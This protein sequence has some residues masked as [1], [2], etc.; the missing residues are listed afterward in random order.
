M[1][2]LARAMPFEG[3]LGG[4]LIG[5]GAA[6]MLLGAGRIAGV[7]GLAAGAVGLARSSATRNLCVAFIIGLPLGALTVAA[8]SGPLVI[9]YSH[10]PWILIA[11]GLLVGFGSRTRFW[12]HKRAWRLRSLSSFAALAR[13]HG[14]LHRDGRRNRCGDECVGRVMKNKQTIIGLLSGILFGVGLAVSGMCDPVRVRAFL[15]IGGAFDPT[16]AF[17]MAGA[18]APMAIA[19]RVQKRLAHPLTSTSFDLPATNTLDASL[20]IGAALF[21]VGW[22]IAGLCPGPAIAGLVLAPAQAAL[23]V[24]AM[25]GGMA[26]HR[27]YQELRRNR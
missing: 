24:V 15:D 14:S 4:L 3:F 25:A 20:V 19:W 22:G 8:L 6:L 13:R 1:E 5:V 11:G 10:T 26:I 9:R 16:L 18:L 27:V 12:M 21:G 23:F 2:A 17:V 7:S